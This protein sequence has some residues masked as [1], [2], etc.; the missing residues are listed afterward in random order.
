[1]SIDAINILDG[2]TRYRTLTRISSAGASLPE[3]NSVGARAGESVQETL[4]R[5]AGKDA[6]ARGA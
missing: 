6:E 5:V 1:M 3:A 4:R 2:E